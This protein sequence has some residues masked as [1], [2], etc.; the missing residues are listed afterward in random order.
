MTQRHTTHPIQ[1]QFTARWSPRAFTD[2]AVSETEVLSLI[3]AARWAPSASNLQPWRFVYALKG[4]PE[5][6]A[7]LSTLVAFNQGWAQHAAALIYL[8]SLTTL[9]GERPMDW[10][11]FD[12]GA[13]WMSLALEAHAKGLAAHAMAGFDPEAAATVLGTPDTVK[14]EAAIAVG[15]T[16]S[17]DSLP[18]VLK[19]REGP[20]DRHPLGHIAFKGQYTH[21]V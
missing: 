6:D 13:A 1:P 7:I 18:D 2:K 14:V 19:E 21:K 4:T 8:V 10:H 20:S 12:A 15:H 9:D 17:P 3:E 11:S 5:F 16:G